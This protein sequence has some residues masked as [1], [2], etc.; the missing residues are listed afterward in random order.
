MVMG[1]SLLATLILFL[2]FNL[3]SAR[4]ENLG[5]KFELSG[6]FQNILRFQTD[7]DFDGSHPIYN[8]SG[9]TVGEFVTFVNPKLQYSLNPETWIFY[10]SELGMDAWSRNNPD[11]AAG[12]NQ[13]ALI[14]KQRQI[15]GET[16]FTPKFSL[17]VGYQ[18][19]EDPSGLFL[20]HW[21]GAASTQIA[22]GPVLLNIAFG[23][24]P[25]QTREGFELD[26]INFH[27][28]ILV[29]S[30]TVARQLP[31][32]HDLGV[33]LSYL[34]D[35]SEIDHARWLF[36]PVLSVRR[37]TPGREI[38]GDIALQYGEAQ[39]AAF[40]G[41]IE[42]TLAWA[43]QGYARLRPSPLQL[44]LQV[45]ALSPDDDF[46]RNGNNYAFLYSGKSRASTMIL[47]EDPIRDWGD[48]LDEALGERTGESQG[49]FFRLR[50]GFLLL[51]A[52]IGY[53]VT[54][55]ITPALILGAA[56]TLNP[57][58]SLGSTFI[59]TE[60][61]LDIQYTPSPSIKID[62]VNSF[63]YP[64]KAASANVNAIKMENQRPLYRLVTSVSFLF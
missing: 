7:S 16:E 64:G 55:K 30:V 35:G 45:M 28:D 15:Y 49:N 57:H 23:Q 3:S 24:L 54:P 8:K 51:D 10:E 46:D 59:G 20:N 37:N 36:T 26:R 34:Y 14:F 18:R 62:L 56:L 17:R 48:N 32:D 43:A 27:N 19:L 61:D 1:I 44:D 29:G 40:G 22:T 47:T 52:K 6:A 63:F 41:N 2:G 50:S 58:N 4:G 31:G 12:E 9:Q 5:E 13:T 21:I 11:F 42:K 33:G 25:D 38:G 60:A 53:P 39:L